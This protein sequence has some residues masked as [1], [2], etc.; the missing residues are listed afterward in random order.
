M[1][2]L[3]NDIKA[4]K[5]LNQK[6]QIRVQTFEKKLELQQIKEQRT[7]AMLD[8]ANDEAEN[9]KFEQ[10]TYSILVKE[11][12]LLDSFSIHRH[13]HEKCFFFS[14]RIKLIGFILGE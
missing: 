4:V 10:E 9:R 1:E 11:I 6:L 13:F 12:I 8:K 7:T 14:L 3:K 5:K 2:R